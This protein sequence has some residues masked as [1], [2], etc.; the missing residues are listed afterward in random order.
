MVQVMLQPRR[1]HGTTGASGNGVIDDVV[2]LHR[3]VPGTCRL[4]IVSR[5]A[6]TDITCSL[7]PRVLTN[8]PLLLAYLSVLYYF[9]HSRT[10][11]THA[12]SDS[13]GWSCA[14]HADMPEHVV[15]RARQVKYASGYK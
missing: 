9:A 14:A 15:A 4:A 3:A 13:F 5:S 8:S 6:G 7:T 1:D 12:C 10:H 11:V 2:F